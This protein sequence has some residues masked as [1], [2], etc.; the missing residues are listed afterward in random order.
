MTA[1][2]DRDNLTFQY[3]EN[4]RLDEDPPRGFPRSISVSAESGAFWCATVCDPHTS[5]DD[6]TRQYIQTLEN[7]YEDLEQQPIDVE[8]GSDI[9]SGLEL[10]FFCLDF[11]VRSLLLGVP[12]RDRNVLLTWQAEDR[13]FDKIEPVFRAISLSLLGPDH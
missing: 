8:L 2:Y 13:E 10:Q 7:E 4:W 3:P 11:L 12:L 6:L 9:V 1:K 5:L